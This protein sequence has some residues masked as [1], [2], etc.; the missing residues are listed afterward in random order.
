MTKNQVL[1]LKEGDKVRVI[2]V[3]HN[4]SVEIGAIKVFATTIVDG[5]RTRGLMAKMVD[6]YCFYSDEIEK[7]EE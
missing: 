4:A 5:V 3:W 6:G 2:K 7:V 1:T